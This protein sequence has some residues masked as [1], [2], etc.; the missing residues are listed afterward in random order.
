MTRAA[1]KPGAMLSLLAAALLCGTASASD[2]F[3]GLWIGRSEGI[4]PIDVVL[5]VK[6]GT[7]GTRSAQAAIVAIGVMAKPVDGLSERDGHL[8]GSVASFAG[9]A[10]FDLQREGADLVGTLTVPRSGAPTPAE[11]RLRLAHTIDAR[12]APGAR[13]WNGTLEA[14]AQRLAMGLV[15]AADGADR[16][17]GAIDIPQQRIN[18]LPLRVERAADGMF[19]IGLP[20]AGDARM[21]LRETDGK[22]AGEFSQG[23][24]TGPIEFTPRAVDAPVP[25]PAPR[26]RPQDPKPPFPYTE[27]T[28]SAKHPDGHVLV[29]TLTLPAGASKDHRVPGVL[30]FTGSGPQDRDESLMGHRPFAVLADALARRGIAVLRCDDR[31]VGKSTGTFATCTTDDFA[32]DAAVE[33]LALA[34]ADEV[35]PARVGI[36]GHSEGGVVAPMAAVQLAKGAPGA[37]RASFLVL[38]AG[39]GV[40]GDAILREQNMRG[41]LATGLTP[42]Q[43]APE[44]AAHAALLDAV[45]AGA[46]EATERALAR[47]LVDAQLRLAGADPETMPPGTMEQ[48]VAAA[49]AQMHSPWMRRFIALDPAEALRS[50]RCPVLVLNGSLDTQVDAKQ[51]V[52]AI[53][54][55]LKQSGAPVTVQVLPGLNHLFQPA[56]TGA[57]AEY[58]QI[59]TTIDPSVLELV[60]TWILAQWPVAAP[61]APAGPAPASR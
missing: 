46:D 35:D 57:L 2:A 1:R 3:D 56:K 26:V 18:G 22:L 44:R 40:D 9:A 43:I 5:G 4:S 47:A 50:V 37:P 36:A 17:A 23:G 52:P 54:A 19:R 24:F 29:G 21:E 15:L 60:P 7:D 33:F 16:W 48:Q 59:E 31:G 25:A 11:F 13:A 41:L 8:A 14:G 49:I 12:T 45:R 53:E 6:P 20:V 42:E 10:T 27:R 51:N 28:V 61:V 55:A 58:A 39:T 30:L 34:G 32:S 38:L